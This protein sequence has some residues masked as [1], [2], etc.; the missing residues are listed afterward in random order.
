MK[1]YLVSFIKDKPLKVSAQEA[2]GIAAAWVR[3]DHAIIFNG[4]V[5]AS[6]Q[7]ASIHPDGDFEK[8]YYKTEKPPR[9]EQFLLPTDLKLL[10]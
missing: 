6:H 9:I 4:R 1:N 7:L 8:D 5:F 3:G 10:K 2:A